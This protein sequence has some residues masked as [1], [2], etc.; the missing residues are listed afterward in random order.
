MTEAAGTRP[1]ILIGVDAGGSHTEAIAGDGATVMARETGEPAC[2]TPER[3]TEAAAVIAALRQRV[4]ARAGLGHAADVLVVGAAGAGRE[5]SRAGL[6]HALRAGVP[7]G[8][9]HVT[10]DA[11]IALESA[12]G[13]GPGIVL[14]AGTGSIALGRDRHGRVWR[15]GGL[16]WEIGDAGSGYAV[17]M[18]GLSALDRSRD[19]GGPPT[20]LTDAIP[21]ALG[22]RDAA[23]AR[24]WGRSADRPAIAR[25]A[26]VVIDAAQ[27]GDQ[28]ATAILHRAVHDLDVLVTALLPHCAGDT[29]V[30]VTLA[31]GMLA[32][33]SPVRAM[34]ANALRRHSQVVVND[35]PVDPAY[36]AMLLAARLVKRPRP[37]AR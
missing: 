4:I 9:V 26:T 3:I 17:G 19:P 32:P 12:V 11:A 15:A 2:L 21:Q 37:A 25:L 31:G 28:L 10:T 29:P 20:V 5:P 30:E 23:H 35:A 6:E 27:R 33:T 34:V 24:A 18:A 22:V 7:D 13:S 36:G 1:L 16:G 14:L 8:T